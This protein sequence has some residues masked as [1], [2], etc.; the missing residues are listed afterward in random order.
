MIEILIL[1]IYFIFIFFSVLVGDCCNQDPRSVTSV[2]D[3]ADPLS[4]RP[5]RRW[6]CDTIA[7]IQ[8]SGQAFG[9]RDKL[10][11]FLCLAAR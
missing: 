11:L 7:K 10:Q 3:Y 8:H 5:A 9:K 6:L 2:R 1:F 4:D